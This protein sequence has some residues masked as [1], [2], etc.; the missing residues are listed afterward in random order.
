MIVQKEVMEGMKKLYKV[1][2]AVTMTYPEIVIEDS[3]C[4]LAAMQ[5]QLMIDQG[6][7]KGQI[8]KGLKWSVSETTELRSQ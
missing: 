6:K 3:N 8:Q 7:I 4:T 2:M 5:Y 1:S